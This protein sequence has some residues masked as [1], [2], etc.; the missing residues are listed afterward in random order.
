MRGVPLRQGECAAGHA[1]TLGANTGNYKTGQGVCD[2]CGKIHPTGELMACS[3][4]QVRITFIFIDRR[5]GQEMRKIRITCIHSSHLFVG[6]RTTAM[7]A[8]G[9][10][11]QG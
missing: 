4:C 3:D 11:F 5:I 10:R 7:P 9:R 6:R 1:L 8:A 2:V